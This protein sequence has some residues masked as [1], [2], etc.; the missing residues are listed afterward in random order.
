MVIK[1]N[2]LPKGV[3][4]LTLFPFIF[5]RTKEAV[6]INHERIH[7]KQQIEMLIIFFYLLYLF[8]WLTK[9]YHGICFEKE[10]YL[11]ESDM[12]YLKE[13]KVFAWAKYS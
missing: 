2:I 12:N 1:T 3:V 5:T 7:L 13:R 11:N 8:E 4:A 9:G 10:C 6:T